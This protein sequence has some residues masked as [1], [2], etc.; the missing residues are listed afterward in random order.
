ML[1]WKM[2]VY[3]KINCDQQPTKKI[4]LYWISQLQIF[5]IK[6]KSNIQSAI[7][8]F[9]KPRRNPKT[10][11]RRFWTE[12]EKVLIF[13]SPYWIHYFKTQKNMKNSWCS[14]LEICNCWI[15]T[16]QVDIFNPTYWIRYIELWKPMKNL[17]ST[18]RETPKYRFSKYQKYILYKNFLQ[19]NKGV[20][21]SV[22]SLKSYARAL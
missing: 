8:M 15:K 20:F 7:L 13:S 19:N 9:W 18:I 5:T 11:K 14:T 3:K 21:R 1:Y 2:V 4:V 16:E 10:S 17:H 12:S 22:R 6:F